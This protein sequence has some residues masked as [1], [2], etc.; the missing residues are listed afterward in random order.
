METMYNLIP[1][2]IW[3]KLSKKETKIYI[4]LGHSAT[5][6]LLLNLSGTY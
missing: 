1:Q 6:K 5:K 2:I 3:T 4:L